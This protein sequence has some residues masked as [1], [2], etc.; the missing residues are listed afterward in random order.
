MKPK[1][2]GFAVQ[3]L[4]LQVQYL[5]HPHPCVES[6]HYDW[7]QMSRSNINQS[8]ILTDWNYPLSR[9]VPLSHEPLY[10]PKQPQRVA[11]KQSIFECL[12]DHSS[13]NRY[14]HVH[15]G[16]RSSF[17]LALQL[18]GFNFGRNHLTYDPVPEISNEM[19]KSAF[20]ASI[21]C[22]LFYGGQVEVPI[23]D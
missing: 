20:H 9:I 21:W 4:P 1:K 15:S 19:C 11:A 13:G 8:Q 6:R 17:I 2:V 7:F 5:T 16:R 22:E 23:V 10:R 3:M 14:F 18:I 12:V